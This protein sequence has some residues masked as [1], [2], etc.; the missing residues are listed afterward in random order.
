MIKTRE[1]LYTHHHLLHKWIAFIFKKKINEIN[2]LN[3]TNCKASNLLSHFSAIP[4][5]LTP[6]LL[7]LQKAPRWD[8]L[9][10]FHMWSPEGLLSILLAAYHS[11]RSM[12]SASPGLHLSKDS[13][14]F[15]F[16]FQGAFELSWSQGDFRL[17]C[18]NCNCNT[19]GEYLMNSRK[20]M[21]SSALNWSYLEQFH[22]W[23]FC[24]TKSFKRIFPILPFW[25]GQY[26]IYCIT[27]IVS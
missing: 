25:G 22:L 5:H 12:F 3:C 1:L 23:V 13:F 27:H 14:F 8:M 4:R 21:G 16:F 24:W 11:F 17:G 19:L 6:V 9:T 18:C 2:L 7:T 26:K 15:F 10:C 20:L